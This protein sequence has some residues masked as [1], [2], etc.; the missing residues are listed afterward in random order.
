MLS[1]WIMAT[2]PKTLA[3]GVA[4]VAVGTSLAATT[5]PV[6]WDLA[7][8]CLGGALLLQIGCNFANDAGDALRGADTPERLGPQRAVA[9]GLIGPRA[10]LAGAGI[11]LALAAVVGAWLAHESA[12]QLWLV[13]L[14]SVVAALAYTLGPMPLAYVG[15][16]DLFVVLFFGLAAVV[17]SAWVQHPH[18]PPPGAWWWAATAVG[19]QAAT[20][21]AINN[22]RDIPTDA[23]TGKRTLCVRL[24]DRASRWYH[25]T[26]HLAA[27][28]SWLAA[29]LPIPALA[30]AALGGAL[31]VLVMRTQ[32]RGLNRCLGMAA[33]VQLAT[34]AAAI[35]C[36]WRGA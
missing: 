15:L 12:W 33:G 24:G 17:G 23:R 25:L 4:P 34:A 26:L 20:L 6:R 14:A 32:G 36:L 2:R 8:G 13:G 3:A 10:M 28:G 30:A 19:M 7:A 29:G 35:G 31:A 16:G 22:L 1:A 9:S 27:A 11:A 21:I 5:G 18:W